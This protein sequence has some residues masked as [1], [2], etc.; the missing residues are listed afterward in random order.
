[1]SFNSQITIPRNHYSSKSNFI[2]SVDPI[3]ASDLFIKANHF[4][5]KLSYIPLKLKNSVLNFEN[6]IIN[7]KYMNSLFKS[8]IQ[9]I[10]NLYQKQRIKSKKIK[11][12]NSKNSSNQSITISKTEKTKQIKK[13]KLINKSKF[14]SFENN[15]EHLIQ[16]NIQKNEHEHVNNFKMMNNLLFKDHHNSLIKDKLNNLV[17]NFNQSNDELTGMNIFYFLN[18]QIPLS[19]TK[20]K[21][22][23]RTTQLKSILLLFF[24][25]IKIE[26]LESITQSF[27][28]DINFK[29]KQRIVRKLICSFESS[30]SNQLDLNQFLE[31]KL[32]LVSESNPEMNFILK[33]L[34]K[35]LILLITLISFMNLF[36]KSKKLNDVSI[37]PLLKELNRRILVNSPNKIITKN[38]KLKIDQNICNKT[39]NQLLDMIHIQDIETYIYLTHVFIQKREK[40]KLISLLYKNEEFSFDLN[41]QE[42]VQ[43][44]CGKV[45][46]KDELIKLGFKF[47]RRQLMKEEF[48]GNLKNN[49]QRESLKQN[50][51]SKFFENDQTTIKFFESF[52]LTKKQV[53]VLK[54]HSVFL[55]KLSDFLENKFIIFLIDEYILN[56]Y[57]SIMVSNIGYCEFIAELFSR[58]HPHSILL[59]DIINSYYET[60]NFLEL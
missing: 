5:N 1:M 56:K 30:T 15:S 13:N 18:L 27:F 26:K 32:D 28:K 20:F 43:I 59:Q 35:C 39:V 40:S 45:K 53:K 8:N 19:N 41:Y 4:E 54:N 22:L 24:K 33:F 2:E 21:S 36:I 14:I 44:L 17:A 49:K 34:K 52:E 48:G 38:L 10:S 11:N 23:Q 46:R 9:F 50:F 37:N 57:N 60:K 51:Y 7:P 25:Y 58:Q 12:E 16:T 29:Q 3:F 47:C 42:Q 6:D 31:M 55:N